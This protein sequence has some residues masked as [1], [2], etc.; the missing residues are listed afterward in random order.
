MYIALKTSPAT[1]GRGG[2]GRNTWDLDLEKIKTVKLKKEKRGQANEIKNY[3]EGKGHT[4]N[5]KNGLHDSD[6]TK[7]VMGV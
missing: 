2:E 1:K 7:G 5:T 4:K 3:K 6:K